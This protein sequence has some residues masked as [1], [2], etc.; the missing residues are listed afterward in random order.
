MC[1]SVTGNALQKLRFKGF[2]QLAVS[3]HFPTG[4]IQK[5]NN[6]NLLTCNKA[7]FPAFARKNYLCRKKTIVCGLITF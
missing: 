4:L 5:H 2:Y 1:L 3:M 6:P 7:L